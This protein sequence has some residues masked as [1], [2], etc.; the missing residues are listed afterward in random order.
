MQLQTSSSSLQIAFEP[1][2]FPV[3]DSATHLGLRLSP[4]DAYKTLANVCFSALKQSLVLQEFQVQCLSISLQTFGCNCCTSFVAW[5][6]PE[7][8]PQ[9][10]RI[11]PD[12]QIRNHLYKCTIHEY[13]S[14]Y[15]NLG[16]LIQFILIIASK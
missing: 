13:H 6:L 5:L 12:T 3:P 1:S 8:G 15:H 11:V 2:A 16:Y 10:H 7:T 14:I 9:T 4:A